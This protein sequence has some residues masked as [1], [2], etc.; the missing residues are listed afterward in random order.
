MLVPLHRGDG[1][2]LHRLEPADF[3]EHGP[4]PRP[5]LRGGGRAR[6]GEEMLRLQQKAYRGTPADAEGRGAHR[7]PS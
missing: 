1:I 7:C 2:D 6:A 3:G 4:R 5:G